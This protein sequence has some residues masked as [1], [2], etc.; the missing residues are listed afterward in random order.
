MFSLFNFLSIFQGSADPIYPYVRTPMAISIFI[1]RRTFERLV[2]S[3]LCLLSVH[4]LLPL[5]ATTKFSSV[6]QRS[7]YVGNYFWPR[8]DWTC[9]FPRHTCGHRHINPNASDSNNF[10]W[11]S[12][13]IVRLPFNLCVCAFSNPATRISYFVY[14]SSSTSPVK[15]GSS[16]VTEPT[17][18]DLRPYLS[19]AGYNGAVYSLLSPST[20]TLYSRKRAFAFLVV[21]RISSEKQAQLPFMLETVVREREFRCVSLFHTFDQ[22]ISVS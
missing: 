7:E 5:Y 22:P 9:S 21:E 3:R 10:V 12:M 1:D 18:S 13:A 6:A 16:G 19:F 14:N 17:N 8:E 20:E 2:D 11:C 4:N 15:P